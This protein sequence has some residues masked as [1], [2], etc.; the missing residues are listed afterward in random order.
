MA[1]YHHQ[2]GTG[3]KAMPST[4]AVMP[5]HFRTPGSET[6]ARHRYSPS[7]AVAV[8]ACYFRTPGT[9][10]E[11]RHHASGMETRQAP[12]METRQAPGMETRHYSPVFEAC[13]THLR[14]SSQG[15]V[16]GLLETVWLGIQPLPMR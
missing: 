15:T 8:I 5:C 10:T 3:M 1:C 9:M 12:G 4:V 11:A 6:E 13:R 2:A 14:V 7:A 16:A